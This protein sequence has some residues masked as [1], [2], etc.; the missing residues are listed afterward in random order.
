MRN[1]LLATLLLLVSNASCAFGGDDGGSTP[2]APTGTAAAPVTVTS[3]AHGDQ[4]AYASAAQYEVVLDEAAWKQM[5][6]KMHA[7]VEPAPALPKVDFAKEAVLAVFSGEKRTTGHSVE[8]ARAEKG[9]GGNVIVTVREKA[10]PAGAMT[11]AS[12]TYPFHVVRI[13][14][15]AGKVEFKT[16]KK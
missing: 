3:I 14:R 10:P 8:V 6:T 16:E 7:D 1:A 15:P 4:Q 2:S 5:W 13:P 11:G 9:A 12:L